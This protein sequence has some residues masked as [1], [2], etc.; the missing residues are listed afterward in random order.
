MSSISQMERSSSQTKMLPMRAASCC[1]HCSV[2]IYTEGC[3]NDLA[4]LTAHFCGGAFCRIQT[5][6]PQDEHAALP[7]FRARPDFAFVSLHNL[8]NDGQTQA[9]AAFKL[10]LE[11]LKNLLNKLRGHAGSGVGKVDLPVLTHRVE[12]NAKCPSTPHG[13]HC[14]FAKIPEHLLDL[15]AIR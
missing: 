11:R 9:G 14:I 12:R 5:P 4:A 15:V 10:G 13:A 1:R 2:A 6:Q 7:K 8:V 3:G